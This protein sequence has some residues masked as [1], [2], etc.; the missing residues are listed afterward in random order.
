M[1]DDTPSRAEDLAAARSELTRVVT[2]IADAYDLPTV[3]TTLML[4][5][6]LTVWAA[7]ALSEDLN[8][9]DTA[10]NPANI[11]HKPN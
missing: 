4:A 1:I 2:E 10:W 7:R 6:E 11:A 5:D 3:Q 8:P 9:G